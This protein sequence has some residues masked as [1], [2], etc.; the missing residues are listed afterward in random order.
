MK[1]FKKEITKE[2]GCLM[3]RCIRDWIDPPNQNVSKQLF[4]EEKDL[5]EI[6]IEGNGEIADTQT[7]N[8][9]LYLLQGV[10]KDFHYRRMNLDGR[11]GYFVSLK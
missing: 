4:T 11:W 8:D 10:M 5:L 6:L 7:I 1:M 9:N 3:E 2:S